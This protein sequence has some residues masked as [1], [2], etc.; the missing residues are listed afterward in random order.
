MRPFRPC[1]IPQNIKAPKFTDM[2]QPL[3]K[4]LRIWTD[5]KWKEHVP[6]AEWAD[7]RWSD[8][9]N[10]RAACWRMMIARLC[11]GYDYIRNYL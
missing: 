1:I 6:C 7:E 3:A 2:P 9:M 10:A 5:K 4:R 11:P 8:S